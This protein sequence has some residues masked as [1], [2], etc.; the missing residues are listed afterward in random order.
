MKLNLQLLI[1]ITLFLS[2]CGGIVTTTPQVKTEKK[3]IN[4]DYAPPEDGFKKSKDISFILIQPNFAKGFEYF[5]YA[6]FTTFSKSMANDYVEML[7]KRGYKYI[8]PINSYDEIVYS[9]KKNTDLLLESELSFEL[10][11]QSPFQYTSG[12][13][14]IGNLPYERY[15]ADGELSISGKI[16]FFVSE[17]FTH[18]KIWVKSIPI[19]TQKITLKTKYY[20]SK[21]ELLN[22]PEV[23]NAFVNALEVVYTKSLQTAW[24]YLDPEELAV[25][26]KESEEI[27]KNSTFTK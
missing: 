15:F 17:P 10:V 2:G 6:P 5:D 11:G 19:E 1:L 23:W 14:M 20:N 12:T 27:R 7:T 13:T 18:T 3:S 8:G 16:N 9:D 22:S 4:Y 25:K 26:K 21:N 24:N